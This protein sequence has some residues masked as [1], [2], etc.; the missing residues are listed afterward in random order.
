MPIIA[1]KLFEGRSLDEKRNLVKA[2]TDAVAT[3]L[4]IGPERV[5][6]TLEEMDKKNHAVG[7]ELAIDWTEPK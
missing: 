6:I 1:I 5:R 7:G 2:V 4:K 3:S